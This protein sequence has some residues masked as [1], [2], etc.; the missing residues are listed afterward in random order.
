MRKAD[1]VRSD[2]RSIAVAD[3]ERGRRPLADAVHREDRGAL[4]RRAEERAGRV[5]RWCCGMNRIRSAGT[6][7][8]LADPVLDPELVEQP[9]GH[10]LAEHRCRV[11]APSRSTVEQDPLELD[12]RLLEE[13][14]VVEIARQ[15]SRPR[16]RQKRIARSGNPK[17]CL[18][19]EKRSS[20]AAA[21]ERPSRSERGRGV[22]KVAGDAEDVHQN[23]FFADSSVSG[24]EPI[25]VH[26]PSP[27]FGRRRLIISMTRPIGATKTK[28]RRN[29]RTRDWISAAR[30][31]NRR[32]RRQARP[33]RRSP[34]ARHLVEVPCEPKCRTR[35][36]M[37]ELRSGPQ[38]RE[39]YDSAAGHEGA[40]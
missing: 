40:R 25:G 32:Q 39:I 8:A 34:G 29:R 9:R 28:Y 12:E 14:D 20:S 1:L 31:A 30:C 7:S 23:W 24:G 6:P 37:R 18:M 11:A 15:S 17:S 13:H 35:R 10:R 22:V 27:R 36:T 38:A 3:A 19:R 33:A 21:D 2:G 26:V 4:E 5:R 16:S